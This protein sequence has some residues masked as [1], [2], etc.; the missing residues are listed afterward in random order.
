MTPPRVDALATL[1]ARAAS[2]ATL[3]NEESADRV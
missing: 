2:L 1:V 3:T